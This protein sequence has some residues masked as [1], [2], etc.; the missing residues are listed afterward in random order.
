M[1]DRIGGVGGKQERAL[2][3]RT[4]KCTD[5]PHKTALRSQGQTKNGIVAL[6]EKGYEMITDIEPITEPHRAL[7]NSE[8][9]GYK[10]DGIQCQA[11]ATRQFTC[12]VCKIR[13]CSLHAFI[14]RVE[15]GHIAYCPTHKPKGG[16]GT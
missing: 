16:G 6:D 7:F 2:V 13:L 4:I 3:G 1:L 12:Q 8:R 14:Q 11:V 9:C 5:P 15:G 10:H